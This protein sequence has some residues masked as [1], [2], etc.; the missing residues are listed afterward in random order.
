MSQV[1]IY[2]EE[3]T[4]A[5]AKAAA[6]R[7]KISLS[8]WMAQLIKQQAPASDA[9]GYPLGFFEQIQ[10]N[11]HAFSDF[12]SLE[13]LRASESPDLPRETM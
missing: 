10:A 3:D 4:L 8:G 2:L 7:A 12:P 9:N 5:A 6:A 1:T 13:T 11:A